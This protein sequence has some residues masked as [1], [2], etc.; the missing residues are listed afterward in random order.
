MKYWHN[1]YLDYISDNFEVHAVMTDKKVGHRL[2]PRL[3]SV[4]EI[5]YFQLKQKP[6]R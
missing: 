4:P 1:N 6:R 2:N 3:V 5:E